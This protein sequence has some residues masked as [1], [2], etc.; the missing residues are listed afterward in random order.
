MRRLAACIYLVSGLHLAEAQIATAEN[1]VYG[2]NQQAGHYIRLRGINLYYETYGQGSPLLMLHF[3]GGSISAFSCNIPYFSRYYKVIA[4][5][6]RAHGKTIDNGDSLTFE[7]MADDFNALLDSLRLDSCYV[8]GW[9]DGGISGLLLAI[10]H[11]DKVKK[12]A[13]TGANLWPDTTVF[14]QMYGPI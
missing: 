11:P 12:L 7:M 5:D 13:V 2:K 1:S 3:N 10:R 8:I 4:V 9:S 6:S 14:C